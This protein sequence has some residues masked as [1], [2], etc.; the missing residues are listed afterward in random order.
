MVFL[1][2]RRLN[3]VAPEKSA[4]PP[5]CFFYLAIICFDYFSIIGFDEGVKN[6]TGVANVRL[7]GCIFCCYVFK[8]EWFIIFLRVV[9]SWLGTIT[10]L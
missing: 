2:M 6:M 7:N 9:V 1:I 10:L 5:F 4:L 8:I 3:F